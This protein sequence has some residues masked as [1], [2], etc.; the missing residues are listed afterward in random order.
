[1]FLY[2]A[3]ITA[4]LYA[5]R[6]YTKHVPYVRHNK[7]TQNRLPPPPAH[8]KIETNIRNAA[9]AAAAHPDDTIIDQNVRENV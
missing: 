9:A 5:I 3:T 8:E 7:N 2:H 6:T 1:M 4:I